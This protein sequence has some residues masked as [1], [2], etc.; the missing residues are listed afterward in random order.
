M[1][2]IPKTE[3]ANLTF[4]IVS[5]ANSNVSL[6]V[7]S[8]N[9]SSNVYVSVDA[10]SSQ[11]REINIQMQSIARDI[12]ILR[13]LANVGGSGIRTTTPYAWLGTASLYK[14]YVEEGLAVSNTS[15]VSVSTQ[16]E[17]INRM[18]EYR[19]FIIDNFDE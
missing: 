6:V 13:Q 2:V 3:Y 7:G 1:F 4:S 15:Q 8:S 18:N 9:T 14:L 19:Q 11:L 12:T 16:T 17:S 5:V 10:S